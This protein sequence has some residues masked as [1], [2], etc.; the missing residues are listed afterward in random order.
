MTQDDVCFFRAWFEDYSKSYP[1]EDAEVEANLRYKREHSLR[2]RDYVLTIGQDLQLDTNHMFLAEVIGL[3]HDVGRFEQYAKYHTFKDHQ[4]EDHAKLGLSV[5]ER[6]KI[7]SGRVS[8]LEKE[9]ILTA[10]KNHNQRV[11]NENVSGDTLMFCRLIRDADKLDI[12]EQVISFYENPLRTPH[13]AVEHNHEEENYSSEVIQGILSG[14][15]ISYT[16]VKTSVDIKLIR[17]SWLLDMTF[18]IA[19]AIAKRKQYLERLRAFIP[20]TVDTLKVFQYIEAQMD[21]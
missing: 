2:V 11:I 19:L 4:S 18:P 8:E 20:V 21:N 14:K 15:Q 12:F 6:A 5:L 16:S 1:A 9:I 7:F 17:L 3:L 13:F 10:I